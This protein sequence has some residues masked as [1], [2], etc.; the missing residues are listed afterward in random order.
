[1]PL[2]EVVTDMCTIIILCRSSALIDALPVFV[3]RSP[4]P[5]DCR[6]SP[7]AAEDE[8]ARVLLASGC[9]GSCCSLIDS[10]RSG[11]IIARIV[12]DRGL[13]FEPQRRCQLL[14]TFTGSQQTWRYRCRLRDLCLAAATRLFA[15]YFESV[16][17]TAKQCCPFPEPVSSR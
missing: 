3:V 2:V 6:S 4:C 1:M 16:V 7:T 10:F 15:E 12:I 5:V 11:G 8:G 17:A 9:L 14:G 13:R